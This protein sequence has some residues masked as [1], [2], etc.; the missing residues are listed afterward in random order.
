VGWQFS[1]AVCHVCH[2][3]HEVSGS[4]ITAMTGFLLLLLIVAAIAFGLEVHHR[5]LSHH[6]P[7]VSGKLDP[8]LFSELRNLHAW[9]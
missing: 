2:C 1:F 4:K 5:R 9:R 7:Y 6:G 8:D 3:W